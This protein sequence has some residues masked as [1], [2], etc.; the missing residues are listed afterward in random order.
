MRKLTLDTFFS[1]A[2][3]F[4]RSQYQLLASLKSYSEELHK[5]RLYPFLSELID[6]ND[7]IEGIINEK[8]ELEKIFPQMIQNKALA[9]DKNDSEE[10]P[11]YVNDVN[12]VF[13]FINWSYPKIQEII[14]EGKA[15]YSFVKQNLSID[16]IGIVPIYKN[17][18]YFFI[19]NNKIELLQ[20]YRYEIP[21]I[22]LDTNTSSLMRIYLMQSFVK[23][24]VNNELL[25]SIKLKLVREYEDLPNPATFRMECDL[26]FPFE[27]T[28]LPIAKRR[29][30]K[31]L[32][33]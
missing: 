11:G 19:S 13:D 18:G 27:E 14:D 2:E 31:K 16:E 30:I 12:Q 22:S 4:E 24:E 33:E 6:M 8:S 21:F 20:V 9:R 15:I 5:N 25:G 3:D 7:I 29:L 32:A 17:E 28:I 26:D 1:A 10:E 23:E